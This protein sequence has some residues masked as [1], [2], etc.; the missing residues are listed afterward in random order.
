[1]EIQQLLMGDL[2][3]Y[4]LSWVP[5]FPTQRDRKVPARIV[6][7]GWGGKDH[8]SIPTLPVGQAFELYVTGG[9]AGIFIGGFIMG[10]ILLTNWSLIQKLNKSTYVLRYSF[11][12]TGFIWIMNIGRPS[13]RTQLGNLSIILLIVL[14]IHICSLFLSSIRYSTAARPPS[15]INHKPIHTVS[16]QLK[17]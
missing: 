15:R 7:P 2:I 3:D 14:I 8:D 10:I 16:Q 6:H 9:W 4:W 13:I 12:I 17:S 1:M 11:A 5:G